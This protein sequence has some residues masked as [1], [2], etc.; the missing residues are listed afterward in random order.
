MARQGD[1]GDHINEEACR[2]GSAREPGT[3]RLAPVHRTAVGARDRW[4][5]ALAH[6]EACHDHDVVIARNRMAWMPRK[7]KHSHSSVHERVQ[8]GIGRCSAVALTVAVR[9][10]SPLNPPVEVES[11]VPASQMTETPAQSFMALRVVRS[12]SRQQALRRRATRVRRCR[13]ASSRAAARTARAGYPRRRSR[14]GRADPASR[15]PG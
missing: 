5:F 11:T 4:R 7:L 10:S 8:S 14:H 2:H 12:P 15:A 3:Q 1:R 6:T 9:G 13:R